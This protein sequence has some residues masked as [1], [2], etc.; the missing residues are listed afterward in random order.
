VKALRFHTAGDL[1]VDDVPAPPDPAG[2]Q[3]V[4]APVLCGICGTD[5][6]E[7]LHGPRRTPTT[8]HPLTGAMN[9]QI[10]GHELAGRVVEVG[11]DV[12]T[13]G[14]GDR[15]SVMPLVSCGICVNCRRGEPHFC[16]I[17]AAIGLRHPWGGMAELLLAEEGQLTLLPEGLTWEQGALVEPTAVSLNAIQAGGLEAGDTVLICG[18]GSIGATA[19]ILAQ[20]LGAGHVVVSDPNTARA[21]QLSGPGVT[22]VDPT[23]ITVAEYCLELTGG[24]DLAIECSGVSAALDDSIAAVR[25]GGRVVVTGF[26]EQARVPIDAQAVMMR[27]VAI[28]GSVG[29]TASMWPRILRLMAAG[30]LPVDAI[31]SSHAPLD[32]AV[33]EGF[34]ALSEPGTSK[35]KVLV[36]CNAL[37]GNGKEP[38][39]EPSERVVHHG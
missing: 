8:P 38:A 33:A 39:Y 3:V 2:H 23:E 6:H 18:A 37:G 21:Q 20:A 24:A 14:P 28:V 26:Q 16:D 34:V 15:V 10:L 9:P 4:V 36:E 29:F 7:Y 31:V 25:P 22:I 11:P 32:S 12:R 19:A 1:R 17:R 13:L 30:R 35:V 27:G 5:V